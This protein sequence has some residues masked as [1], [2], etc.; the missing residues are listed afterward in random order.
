MSIDFLG[1]P[2]YR[3]VWRSG[4]SEVLAHWGEVVEGLVGGCLEQIR[5]LYASDGEWFCDAPVLLHI[6][7]TVLEICH[8]KFDELSI[9]CD[10]IDSAR[11]VEWDWGDRSWEWRKSDLTETSPLTGQTV[12]SMGFVEWRGERDDIANGMV[13][14]RL[15]VGDETLLVFNGLDENAVAVGPPDP[16]YRSIVG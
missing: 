7:D 2:G 3:P 9:T 5:L 11:P 15:D 10:T 4:A 14:L 12:T 6:G 8:N 13:A 1:I 16:R